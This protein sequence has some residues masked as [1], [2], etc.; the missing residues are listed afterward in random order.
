MPI[1]LAEY[2]ARYFFTS[3]M[4]LL[5]GNRIMHNIEDSAK[6]IQQNCSNKP[7]R[8][9]IRFKKGW[10]HSQQQHPKPLQMRYSYD[11][12]FAKKVQH[13][14]TKK[15]KMPS[16][17]SFFRTW[18]CWKSSWSYKYNYS[19]QIYVVG[20]QSNEM[21][22]NKQKLCITQRDVLFVVIIVGGYK[23]CHT[24]V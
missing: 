10:K 20:N 14:E 22:I 4:I 18:Y 2:V 11:L 3:N 24:N 21:Y 8:F 15:F 23:L 6:L 12:Q 7:S 19:P 17:A 1:F 9:I 5:L 16:L 13:Q